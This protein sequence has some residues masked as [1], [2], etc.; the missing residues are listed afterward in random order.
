[1]AGSGLNTG[2]S[3]RGI[4]V[5]LVS[6]NVRGLGGPIKRSR[7]FSH[8]KNLNSDIIFLQETHLRVK[9]H[10]R[11][12]KPWI[13]QVFHSNFNSRAR[14][15]AIVM[16]KRVNF[17]PSQIIAD[18]GGRY[19][20]VVGILFHMSVV[21]VNIYAPNWDNPTFFASLFSSIPNLNSHYLI[22][23]GDFNC[24]MDPRYDRS[25][26][27]TLEQTAMAKAVSAFM[28]QT[29]CADPWRFLNPSKKEFSFFSSVHQ[30][31]S[32]IDYFFLDKALLP[33]VYSSEYSAIVISDHA[34]HSLT[35][36]FSN[37]RGRANQ[38]RFDSG[39]LS[40]KEFCKYI[41]TNI[42]MF[43]Q[44][45][46]SDSVSPSLLWETFKVVIRGY[47]ISYA[48]YKYK[49]RK[50]K[51]QDLVNYIIETDRQLLL[52]PTPELRAKKIELKTEFD[53][54]STK[55]AEF[56]LRRTKATYYEHGDKAGRLLASQ[57]KGLTAS[58]LITQVY[59]S[60]GSLTKN[61]SDINYV[62][63]SY[64]SN[65]YKSEPPQDDSIMDSFLDGLNFPQIDVA[66]ADDLDKPIELDAIL[67]GI[68][69]MQSGKAAGPDGFPIDF[70][71]M[72]A[73]NLAPLLLD[74]YNDSLANG[75]LPLTITQASISLLLKRDKNPDECGNW[76]PISLLNSDVKL[77]AKVL[78]CRLDPCLPKIISEDQTGFIRGRQLSSNIRR[79]LNI[80]FSPSS[81]LSSEII[82][83]LD[84]EK[85]FDR[86]EWNYLFTI[87]DRFGFG[88]SFTSWIR[89]LYTAPVA[90]VRTNFL[91]SQYFPLSRG[92]RQ[93]CPLSPLLFAL[94]IEPLSIALKNSPFFSGI[95]RGGIEHRVSLYADDLLLFVAN[96]VGSVSDLLNILNNFGSFS[97]YKLNIN[98]SECFPVNNMAKQIPV[99][100]LPF[101]VSSTKFRYLGVNISHSFDLLYQYNF[102]KLL[103]QVKLDLQR[104]DKLPLTLFGRIQSIKM[105]ILP[106]FLFLF[107]TLPVFLPK[108]FFKL[109]DGAIS[110]FIWQGRPPRLSKAYL[111]R[112]KK[113]GGF[114]LP[115]F[116]IYYWAANISKIHWY[117]SPHI[118]WCVLEA[119]SCSSSS[120]SALVCAPLSNRPSKYTNNPVVCSSLRIW[121]QFRQHFKLA[122]ASLYGP[123]CNNHLFVPST[124]DSA[125]VLWKNRGLSY[126]SDLFTDGVFTTFFD[127]SKKFNIPQSNL[128]RF[129]QVRNFVNSH[130]P[131]FPD[132]SEPSLYEKCLIQKHG[133]ISILYNL[134][135][136]YI[137]PSSARFTHQ[138]ET[139]LGFSLGQEWWEVAADRVN[140]SSSCAKLSLIQFK[141]FHRIHLTNI[142]LSKIFPGVDVTCNRCSLA[143]AD[144]THMFFTCP[145]LEDFWSSFF[146]TFSNILNVSIDPCPLIAIFGV[147]A[148]LDDYTKKYANIL[149]FA[150]LIARRRILL[151]WKSTKPP[152]TFSW[153]EDLMSFLYIEKIKFA[154]RGSID[155]F[156]KN[157]DPLLNFVKKTPSI[158]ADL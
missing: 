126:F 115:N 86:V 9:D 71:K 74:M 14:G 13:G 52:N 26:P 79:L 125:Y 130:C 111:Q 89:L 59:D 107:Q 98:K 120:L 17:S 105:N 12:R 138:W 34:P 4:S 18:P 145:K 2:L 121:R 151:H 119:Q 51:L 80:I 143:P 35:L 156:Y 137:L 152:P 27:K 10:V 124:L 72:F 8:L 122:A 5:N 39:L 147:P 104:W 123:I 75:F 95:V 60:S 24:V 94:A 54:L 50:Q 82:I 3:S 65:L 134:I 142:K 43:I 133:S 154:L 61:P 117:N 158:F 62:F 31:Y 47:I 66:V 40:D 84:A 1:M 64:Y 68:Q 153:L 42:D 19:V 129:F 63:F 140:S 100:A 25:N 150:S 53:L 21:F 136:P 44:T 106:R 77:L 48:G 101:H 69:L 11:L 92:T 37:I 30:S 45:N 135:L 96:P 139:E 91:C 85:A 46:K 32:R 49:Q 93:G 28:T 23:G 81:S 38:W 127:L 76:R 108:S 149:A 70:Y 83:S 56:M 112:H 58:R 141:V 88:P 15:T 87:L 155:K 6:W 148:V 90:S 99:G 146:D 118:D 57:L 73:K 41:S 67:K 102:S 33:L 20:I 113:V 110:T 116:L 97:G 131:S 132:L 157:W 29:G 16:H 7:V 78:A 103:T 144:H 22:L 128:F 109:L 55:N 114:A 36:S